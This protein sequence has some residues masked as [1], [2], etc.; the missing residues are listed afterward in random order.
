MRKNKAMRTAALLLVLVLMTSCFVGGTFAKYTTT[1]SGS[2]S[3]RVAYW[4][5][6]QTS[7][8][9]DLF[10]TDYTDVVSI[11]DDN[12]IAPGTGMT[13]TFGFEYTPN[14]AEGAEAPEVDY[15][16]TVDATGECSDDI[17]NN[18]N[19]KWYV[20]GVLAVDPAT[21]NPAAEGSWNA[22]LAQLDGMSEDVLAGN[23]PTSFSAKD[24]THTVSWVWD[25]ETVENGAVDADQDAMD[26]AMGNKGELDTVLLTITITATQADNTA[27]PVIAP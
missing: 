9:L 6:G 7:L 20:D 15:T 12:V 10:S 2:E 13:A 3:A 19:I 26:T 25:F 27:A 14:T 11:N 22:M 18:P 16:F 21:T 17:Q 5:F 4:G 8:T 23:L 24:T 1:A